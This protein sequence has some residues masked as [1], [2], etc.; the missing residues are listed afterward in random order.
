MSGGSLHLIYAVAMQVG[1]DFALHD[2]GKWERKLS[3]LSPDLKKVRKSVVFD[4]MM[5]AYTH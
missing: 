5:S 3:S 1:D 4:S 2:W